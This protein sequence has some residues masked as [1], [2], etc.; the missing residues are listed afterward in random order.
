MD[1]DV[2]A[3][4][5]YRVFY[6]AGERSTAILAYMP[7]GEGPL[8]GGKG[9]IQQREAFV[10]IQQFFKSYDIP[11]PDIFSVSREE[12]VLLLEDLGD[13]F[14]SALIA[15]PEVALEEKRRF[16]METIDVL[17]RIQSIPCTEEGAPLS[18]LQER[19]PQFEQLRKGPLEL[20]Q[21]YLRESRL[22]AS[23]HEIFEEFACHLS[24]EI[25]SHP[26]VCCHYDFTGYNVHVR[27][28]DALALIDFQDACLESPARDLHAILCDRDMARHLEQPLHKE[29]FEY[30]LK[31]LPGAAQLRPLYCEYAVHWDM[32]VAGRFAKLAFEDGRTKYEQ[33][34][35]HTV[36]RL[37][38]ELEAIC[39][40][41]DRAADV[42]DV[43]LRKAPVAREYAKTAWSV[44]L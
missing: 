25:S 1:P 21:F 5:Y 20:S 4:R 40:K 35:P 16:M 14:L 39:K 8:G 3:R 11:V 31:K 19:K 9:K 22:T 6:S 28:S 10:Q 7:D 18:L 15:S 30:A 33:W 27:D 41:F 29:L 23:E 26:S 32:R 13:R 43:L 37:V 17:A 44:T 2:S 38:H 42:L 34:I 24:E 36:G 12:R